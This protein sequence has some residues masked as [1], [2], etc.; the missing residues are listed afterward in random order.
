MVQ[1]NARRFL[2]VPRP[3]VRRMSIP[4]AAAIVEAARAGLAARAD[5][6]AAPGMQAYMKSAMPFLGVAA[7]ARERAAAASCSPLPG[8]SG[9]GPAAAEVLWDGARVREE[10]YVATALARRLAGRSPDRLPVHRHWIV[11]GAWWDH[12]DEIAS[13]LVGPRCAPTRRPSRRCCAPGSGDRTAGC[14]ARR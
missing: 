14:A 3:T 6:A 7:P 8:R 4:D 9:R 2:S 12:V 5:P 10:R 13:R 1:V 11:T